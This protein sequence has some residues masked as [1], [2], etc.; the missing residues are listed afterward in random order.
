MCKVARV[1]TLVVKESR[2]MRLR[3]QERMSGIKNSREQIHHQV[4]DR[5]NG[6]IRHP[7]SRFTSHDTPPRPSLPSSVCPRRCGRRDRRTDSQTVGCLST[8]IR[9]RFSSRILSFSLAWT[10]KRLR[11][12]RSGFLK[13]FNCRSGTRSNINYQ[14]FTE[15]EFSSSSSSSLCAE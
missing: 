1:G 9:A 8:C 15:R 12:R 13:A 11:G 2:R 5:P 14:H 3:A 10:I 4:N 6:V 7:I